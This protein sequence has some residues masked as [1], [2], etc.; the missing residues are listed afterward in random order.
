M[1]VNMPDSYYRNLLLEGKRK[2]LQELADL[3][4]KE[5]TPSEARRFAAE[6]QSVLGDLAEL[7]EKIAMTDGPT[8]LDYRGDTEINISVVR[9]LTAIGRPATEGEIIRELIRGQF[10]K[11]K[12]AHKMA[13]RV[14]RCVRSYDVGKP[15][16]NPKLRIRKDLVGWPDKMFS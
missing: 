16:E 11:Y 3:A 9:Y 14:G 1:A 2:K 10:P 15:S 4:S 5:R 13:I 6:A 7:D 12:D 8:G